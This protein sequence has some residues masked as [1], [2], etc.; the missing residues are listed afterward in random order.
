MHWLTVSCRAT[1]SFC[2]T[3]VAR[4]ARSSQLLVDPATTEEDVKA[5]ICMEDGGPGGGALR[6]EVW[7]EKSK[8]AAERD[9]HG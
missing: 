7:E 3:K 5:D 1:V 9:Y 8:K 2:C 6:R 4:C